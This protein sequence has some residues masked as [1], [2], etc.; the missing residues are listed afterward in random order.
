VNPWLFQLG[1]VAVVA[2]GLWLLLPRSEFG[3]RA[4]RALGG[5]LAAGG[6]AL[7]V[8]SVPRLDAFLADKAFLVLAVLSVVSAAASMTFR[9]PVYCAIW[10]A[11]TLLGVASLLL[12]QGAEFLGVA[13]LVVYAGAILVTFLFVLMLAQPGGHAYY[14][15]I[16]WEAGFSALAG[17]CMIGVLTHALGGAF[18]T[19]PPAKLADAKPDIAAPAET[20]VTTIVSPP[21]LRIADPHTAEQRA[22]GVLTREHV[23]ALGG[24][25]FSRY[26]IAV[27]VGGTLLLAAL[28]GAVAMVA[29]DRAA[30]KNAAPGET[31]DIGRTARGAK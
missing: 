27:E 7:L 14:D 21:A 13:T 3:G 4:V 31:P 28:V 22:A 2:L 8:A 12:F 29:Q 23:A 15:R 24:T 18:E 6:V 30:P 16:S 5:L 26:L 20:A 19:P 11:V 1:A 25:L 9:S 10:F 17:A